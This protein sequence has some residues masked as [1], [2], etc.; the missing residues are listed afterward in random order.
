MMKQGN[1]VH[2]QTLRQLFKHTG[3][4][5][6]ELLVKFVFPIG[7]YYIQVVSKSPART[8]HSPAPR[9]GIRGTTLDRSLI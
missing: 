8:D 2:T 3:I 6:Y 9:S 7:S 4:N 1:Q 5:K